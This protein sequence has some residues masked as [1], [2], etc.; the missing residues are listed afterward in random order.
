MSKTETTKIIEYK[1][2]REKK[3]NNLPLY[4]HYTGEQYNKKFHS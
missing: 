3:I 2:N 4:L 1:M